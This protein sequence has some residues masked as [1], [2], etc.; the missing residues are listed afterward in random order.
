MNVSP[1][2]RPS[3]GAVPRLLDR[4]ERGTHEKVYGK[5]KGGLGFDCLPIKRYD[6]SS[7]WQVFNI[8][9]FNLVRAMQ[10]G[11]T[12]R[13][14]TNRRRRAIRPF[15]T[16]QPLRYGLIKRA[17]PLVQPGGRQLLEVGNNHMVQERFKTIESALAA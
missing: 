1:S 2:S 15:Q 14:S 11:T 5:L 17:G 7:A 4:I 16:T 12:E 8:L 6:A 3:A 9:A 13:R 10:A